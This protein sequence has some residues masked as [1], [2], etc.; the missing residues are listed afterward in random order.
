MKYFYSSYD[1][2]SSFLNCFCCPREEISISKH[3]LFHAFLT[4]GRTIW[5][6][7][8]PNDVPRIWRPLLYPVTVRSLGWYIGRFIWINSLLEVDADG[9]LHLAELY[10]SLDSSEKAQA[11]YVLATIITGVTAREIHSIPWLLHLDIAINRGLVGLRRGRKRGD[12]I[13]LNRLANQWFVIETKGRERIS[14][15]VLDH[16]KNQVNN[17][18]YVQDD[19]GRLYQISRFVSILYVLDRPF[20]NSWIDPSPKSKSILVINIEEFLWL[21][22]YDIARFILEDDEKIISLKEKYLVR[23][24]LLPN[25]GYIGIGLHEEILKIFVEYQQKNTSP[26]KGPTKKVLTKLYH[27]IQKLINQKEISKGGYRKFDS[28]IIGPDAVLVFSNCIN[29]EGITWV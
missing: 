28:G 11:S 10:N 18:A 29:S 21:Y 12:L 27:I 13:G 20:R 24:F 4:T 22:Y 25:Q 15:N 23:K 6:F 17:I 5:F 2:I 1:D 26:F 14:R 3:T 7:V 9:K 19:D 16:A 8:Y